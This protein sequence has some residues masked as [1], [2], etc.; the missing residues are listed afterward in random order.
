MTHTLGNCYIKPLNHL[1]CC[2]GSDAMLSVNG[3]VV[4][5]VDPPS[6]SALSILIRVQIVFLMVN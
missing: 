2:P 3:N 6:S 1:A 4:S 5:D